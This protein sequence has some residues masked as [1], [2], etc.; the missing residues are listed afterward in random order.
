MS[1]KG[2]SPLCFLSQQEKKITLD[3]TFHPHGCFQMGCQSPES[4]KAMLSSSKATRQSGR[5]S[6]QLCDFEPGED[7]KQ[8]KVVPGGYEKMR[9]GKLG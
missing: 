2:A 7:R 3:S 9:L 8:N 5:E 1:V 4:G 6:L